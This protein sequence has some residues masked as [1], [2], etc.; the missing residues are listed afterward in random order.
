PRAQPTACC[1]SGYR[2]E[3][4]PETVGLVQAWEITRRR[5]VRAAPALARI[6]PIPRSRY[7]RFAFCTGPRWR[8]LLKNFQG[9]DYAI[10]SFGFLALRGRCQPGDTLVG[11]GHVRRLVRDHRGL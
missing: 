9:K 2:A 10:L 3:A 8:P 4:N 6:P 11:A 5:P 1:N 7:D